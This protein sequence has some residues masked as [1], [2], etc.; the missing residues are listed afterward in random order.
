MLIES[1]DDIHI[2]DMKVNAGIHDNLLQLNPFDFEF[3]KYKLHL[4]G[5]NN[6]NGKL[7]YHIAVM[8]SPIP[9]P[10]AINIE[11]MFHDPKLRFGGP[12]YNLKRAE[13]VTSQIEENNNINLVSVA[14][15]FMGAFIHKAAEAAEDPNLSI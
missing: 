13:E 14:R 6:F 7:Y 12:K 3:D 1:G 15:S 9:F 2:K 8:Q 11:G 4:L 5:I 10:F